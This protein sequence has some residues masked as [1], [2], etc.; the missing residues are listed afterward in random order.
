M[1]ATILIVE[2]NAQNRLLMGD[3]LTAHGF[4]ILEARD[5]AE[6]IFFAKKHRPDLILLDMQMPV[7]DGMEAARLLKSDPETAAIKILAVTSFAMKGDRER[8]LAVGVDEYMAKPI[9]TRQLPVLIRHM[10]G[11]G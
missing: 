1:A 3:I 2:D 4:Q 10:L 5:G 6:G 8:I 11:A 9:D 7:M